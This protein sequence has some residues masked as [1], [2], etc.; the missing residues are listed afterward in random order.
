MSK[1][2]EGGM[3]TLYVESCPIFRLTN[4]PSAI[5]ASHSAK[6]AKQM[7]TNAKGG[8][9]KLHLGIFQR[10]GTEKLRLMQV[11]AGNYIC[12]LRAE[13]KLVQIE[14]HPISGWSTQKVTGK[15]EQVSSKPSR[16]EP[17]SVI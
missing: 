14:G 1:A 5:N 17:Q 13:S 2:Q 15:A 7:A 3:E 9:S 4:H 8:Q 11:Q 6:G 10:L 16:L 12:H